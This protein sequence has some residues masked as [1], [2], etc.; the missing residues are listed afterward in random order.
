MRS[1]TSHLLF[2]FLTVAVLVPAEW[3]R[4]QSPDVRWTSHTSMR[5]IT[6][7]SASPDAIWAA[8]TGGVFRYEV[9][10]GEISAYTASDGLHNVQTQA[11]AYDADRDVV[12][13]GY[14]DGVLDRLNPATG[15]IETF[16]DIERAD[17][18]PSRE[19]HLLSVRG[20]SLFVG[21]SFG[22]VVFEPDR[23][24]VRDT[25]SQLGSI[26]PGTAVHDLTIAPGP[27]GA[28]TL[29]LATN[30]GV[31][32]APLSTPNLQ[33]PSGWTVEQV[34]LP[35]T[36]TRSIAYFDGTIYVGAMEDLSRR[37]P[38]GGFEAL[39][40]TGSAVWD[41]LPLEDRLIGAGRFTLIVVEPGGASAIVRI[42]PYSNPVVLEEGPA[43]RL[44]IG[45]TDGGLLIA[46]PPT[47][48]Q[49]SAEILEG[50]VYPSGPYVN[51]FS[52]LAVG[53][54]GTLWAAGESAP[55]SGFHRF[56]P[57]AGWT[58]YMARFTPELEGRS[59]FERVYVEPDG[60]VWVGSAGNGLAEVAVDGTVRTYDPTNSSLRPPPGSAQTYVFVGGIATD[61]DGNLWLTSRASP[62]PL[63]VRT[64]DGEWTGISGLACDGF[65]TTGLTL[66]HIV[67]DSFGQKWIIV[68][69]ERNLRRVVGLLVLDT[70]GTPSD[71]SDDRCRFF[72]SEGSGGQG[73]P[74]TTVTSLVED[75]DGLMW[76][77]TDK[78]LA[79]MIN[80][81]IVASDPNAVPIWP[82]LADRTEGTFLLNGI[83]I[84]D[85]AIDP[86]NRLWVATDQ[87]VSVVQQVENG[88]EISE[89]FTDRNSPLFSNRVGDIEVDPTSGRVYMA[90]SQGLISFE[91]DAIAASE[92]VG[93]LKVYPN[94]ARISSG[95][96][97]SIFVEGLVDATEL[98]VVTIDGEVVARVQ[99]RGGRARWD[100]RDLSGELV[101]SGVY[102]VVAVGQN[103]EGAAY[104]KVAV[105]R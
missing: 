83:Q 48:S 40:R 102:L 3:V 4:G 44:W 23:E 79:F 43:G 94:P 71:V 58:D 100:G 32:F 62:F 22:L 51:L 78:G 26:A 84:N 7:V 8:T 64:P 66:D 87:G 61:R 96:E 69:D 67:I 68:L 57:A 91:S 14:R 92:Q 56:D 103:G 13:I 18:F 15:A 54:D 29:W 12:W 105:V 6:D 38:E 42:D 2:L 55:E 89:A 90:T 52:D 72:S 82:Q 39:G 37:L 97:P 80:N 76:I 73:L 10:T 65:T 93:D 19:I 30:D 1:I 50:D 24:E 16:R 35:S 95:S 25:Y 104:G 53:S 33:D 28:E 17:R 47:A 81:S 5:E 45:D 41:L 85:L 21:T 31:A 46:D 77:G 86:A 60:S 101:P 74:G 34:G 75:R 20:D 59:S 49:T 88:Y 27:D 70:A 36:E 98:R 99:T 63:H 9:A 11:I